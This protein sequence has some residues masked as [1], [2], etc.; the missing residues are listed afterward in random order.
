MG[1]IFLQFK[2]FLKYYI[3]FFLSTQNY[4]S[5]HNR[6]DLK[7]LS[8]VK[9]QPFFSS[10]L[11]SYETFSWQSVLVYLSAKKAGKERKAIDN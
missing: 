9:N 4:F 1:V 11:W 5:W 10:L 3:Y 7:A 2:M 8:K 6:S